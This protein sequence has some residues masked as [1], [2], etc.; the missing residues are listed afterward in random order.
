MSELYEIL[1]WACLL[2]GSF[3]I[4][5]GAIGV[6]RMPDFFTRLHA[7]SLTDTMGAGLIIGA[8]MIESG[9]TLNFVRLFLI[10]FFL[11]FTSP[12]ATH[13]LSHAALLQGLKPWMRKGSGDSASAGDDR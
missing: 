7:A 6:L 11:M 3:F 10:L 12:V 4:V 1:A 13:A 2:I 8:L 9:W 5:V